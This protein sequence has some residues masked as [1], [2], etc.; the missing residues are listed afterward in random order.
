[1]KNELAGTARAKDGQIRNVLIDRWGGKDV[2]IGNK[3]QPGPLFGVTADCWQ[4]LAIAVT[5]SDALDCEAA[6]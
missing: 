4:V 3:K 5:F 6:A 1:V 2:A